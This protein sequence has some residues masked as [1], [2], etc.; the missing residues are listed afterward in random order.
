MIVYEYILQGTNLQSISRPDCY[1]SLCGNHTSC[2]FLNYIRT[3]FNTLTGMILNVSLIS[4]AQD[5]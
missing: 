1:K 5:S 3:E 2:N 4:G